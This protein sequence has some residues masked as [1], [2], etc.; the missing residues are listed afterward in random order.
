MPEDEIRKRQVQNIISR[1]QSLLLN[2]KILGADITVAKEAL[3]NA[4][5]A[6]KDEAYDDAIEFAK[7]SMIE[8]MRL[9]RINEA[10]KFTDED[11]ETMK[12]DELIKKCEMLGLETSGNKSDLKERLLDFLDEKE[13]SL[14]PAPAPELAADEV[15]DV[16]VPMAK[17][18]DNEDQ[19]EPEPAPV[20][21][22]PQAEPEAENVIRFKSKPDGTDFEK[23][24]SYLIQE[25]RAHYCF[26]I[27]SKILSNNFKG[28]CI[29]RSNP[30]KIKDMFELK[31]VSMYWL[32]DRESNK[33][34]TI[35]PSLENMI[36][37]AEEFIDRSD[38]AV[39]LLDGLEYLIS[40]NS[41]NP[42]LRFIRR[43]IDKISETNSILLISVS[44]LAINEQELKLLEREMNPIKI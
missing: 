13:L 8:I 3:D 26:D 25:D 41:F 32:T 23:G 28:L 6:F 35:S 31:N 34:T 10:E 22:E 44:P 40:N 24:V 1:S 16:D 29:C 42:V 20:P 15:G 21:K 30:A 17:V 27:L 12:K 43:L 18:V 33:E 9:K 14:E 7:L 11:L 39:L 2:V 38:E 19:P 36:Y 37:V 4:R 5:D